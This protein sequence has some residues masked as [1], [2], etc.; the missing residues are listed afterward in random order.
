MLCFVLIN[1]V[2]LNLLHVRITFLAG[3]KVYAMA[4][5]VGSEVRSLCNSCSFSSF[6]SGLFMTHK[7]KQPS[8]TSLPHNM[9]SLHLPVLANNC[10]FFG[11]EMTENLNM[12]LVFRSCCERFF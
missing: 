10:I 4:Q 9:Q 6:H 11:G 1:R 3:L 5:L 8:K 2:P 12:L 7:G